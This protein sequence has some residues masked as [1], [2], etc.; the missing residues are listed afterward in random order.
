MNHQEIEDLANFTYPP[1][2]ILLE[3]VVTINGGIKKVSNILKIKP[4]S[5]KR[6]INQEKQMPFAC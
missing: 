6:F 5:L 2:D 4:L 3:Q 1:T